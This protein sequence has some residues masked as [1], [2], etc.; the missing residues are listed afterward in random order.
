MS[1]TSPALAGSF[2]TA[3][4]TGGKA[5]IQCYRESKHCRSTATF[6]FETTATS[7][8]EDFQS[9]KMDP[10]KTIKILALK[11]SQP[12]KSIQLN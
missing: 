9:N 10:F 2:L 6:R 3:S 7:K 4:A 12:R 5:T 8:D 1:L 11:T